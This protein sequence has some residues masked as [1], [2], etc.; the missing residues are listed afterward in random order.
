V[1]N[2]G[3]VVPAARA[4]ELLEPF[5]RLDGERTDARGAGLG[6]SIVAAIAAAHDA[7]LRPT[8]RLDGGLDVEVSFPP[9]ASRHESRPSEPLA[10]AGA[11]NLLS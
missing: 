9:V 2:S 1:S 3:L 11:R 7:A 8:P 10:I 4:G 5:R 6:L